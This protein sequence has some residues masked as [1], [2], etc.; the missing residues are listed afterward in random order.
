[1][2][3]LQV[4]NRDQSVNFVEEQLLAF[5]RRSMCCP[6]DEYFVCYLAVIPGCNHWVKP[7]CH[8]T[9]TGQTSFKPS[10]INDFTSQALQVFKHYRQQHPAQQYALF[11]YGAL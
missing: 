5:L 6:L 4:L 10:T 7:L 2:N 8:P 9:A 3:K 1:M 11:I